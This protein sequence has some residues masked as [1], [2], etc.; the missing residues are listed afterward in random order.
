LEQPLYLRLLIMKTTHIFPLILASAIAVLPSAASMAGDV[1]GIITFNAGTPAKAGEVNAN[2]AAVKAASDDNNARLIA[3]ENTKQNRVTGSC[4][5]GSAITAIAQDGTITCTAQSPDARFGTNTS[6]AVAGR[7]A[8]CTLGDVFLAAGSI[9]GAT[10]AAGQILNIAQNT[11]LFSLLGTNYG[12]NGTSTFALP[13]LRNVAPN[14][15]TYV[16][17]VTGVFPARN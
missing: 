11:A 16:I 13:D 17:C 6:N 15:L 7:G 1:T 14:G 3:V 4:A 8:T 12:G 2:F 10:P 5:V 9:A